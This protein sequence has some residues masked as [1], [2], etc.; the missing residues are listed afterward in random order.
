MSLDTILI[1]RREGAE[2]GSVD[3]GGKL[4]REQRDQILRFMKTIGIESFVF[5]GL[6]KEHTNILTVVSRES[7][8]I[9]DLG[10]ATFLC[11]RIKSRLG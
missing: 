11:E 4:S 7:G 2:E 5:C 1:A 8:K 10:L 6:S 3:L 9:A